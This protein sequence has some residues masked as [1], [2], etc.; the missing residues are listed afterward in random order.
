MKTGSEDVIWSETDNLSLI[1]TP[2]IFVV[3]LLF[4]LVI[5][6][7]AAFEGPRACGQILYLPFCLFAE[8]R[9]PYI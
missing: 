4:A 9:K 6:G 8:G 7:S 3:E 2:R 5:G 1:V